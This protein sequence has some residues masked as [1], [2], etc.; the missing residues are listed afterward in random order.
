M[1]FFDAVVSGFKNCFVFRGRSSRSEFWWF[2]LFY[3]MTCLIALSFSFE[4]LNKELSKSDINDVS[5]VLRTFLSSWLG[6]ALLITYVPQ[7]ALSIRRFHDINKSGWW[8]FGLQ[9][10]PSI[11][12]QT[13]SFIGIIT[14]FAY[15]YFMCEK[16]GDENQ[17]GSNPLQNKE[18]L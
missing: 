6:I 16:G 1:I 7:I 11:L 13:L 2:I 10:V 5:S 14:L 18:Q 3:I 12:T 4:D 15:L 8:F 17:Y 9:I